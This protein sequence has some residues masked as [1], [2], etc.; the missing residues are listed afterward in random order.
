MIERIKFIFEPHYIFIGLFWKREIARDW[1]R[2]VDY[3]YVT[4]IY[5]ICFVPCF[6]LVI[7]TY[8]KMA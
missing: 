8:K 6:P 2:G 1:G 3:G 5:F 7:R 4:T